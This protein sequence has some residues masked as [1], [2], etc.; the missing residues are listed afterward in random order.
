MEKNQG[1]TLIALVITIIILLILAGITISL[2]IGEKGI[3]KQAQE[4]GVKISEEEAKSKLELVLLEMQSE[5]VIN[6]QYNANEYLSAKIKE[7]GILIVEDN[8]D[9][10]IVDDWTFKIDRS[11]PQMTESLGKNKKVYSNRNLLVY[12]DGED[13]LVDNIWKDRSGN[14]YDAIMNGTY[15]HE[16][17]KKAYTFTEEIGSGIIK[18]FNYSE[19]ITISARVVLNSNDGAQRLHIGNGYAGPANSR[20]AMS[21]NSKLFEII[22]GTSGATEIP[23]EISVGTDYTVTMTIDK[24]GK[25]GKMYLNGQ[26]VGEGNT[27]TDFPAMPANDFRIRGYGS[28][29]NEDLSADGLSLLPVSIKNVL[30]YD[31]ELSQQEVENI[32][33][34][35][36]Q[37]YGI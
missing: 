33:I 25:K 14:N 16:P 32:Y 20:P 29:Y 27:S 37:K 11:I 13:A 18:K 4:A 22:S 12:L 15:I 6:S 36:N 21:V 8:E 9:Y 34:V 17:D 30:V 1:I 3:F 31:R 19:G 10:V 7:N 5:K 35:D 28:V 26:L 24:T 23:Y 2:T